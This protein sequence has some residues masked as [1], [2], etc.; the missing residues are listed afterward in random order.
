MPSDPH[1]KGSPWQLREIFTSPLKIPSENTNFWHAPTRLM[2]H[3]KSSTHGNNPPLI[4]RC[5]MPYPMKKLIE[6]NP[7]VCPRM[8]SATGILAWIIVLPRFI[9]PKLIYPTATVLVLFLVKY[10]HTGTAQDWNSFTAT[11]CQYHVMFPY[12]CTRKKLMFCVTSMQWNT[13]N[14]S[15]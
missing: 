13:L 7:R 9:H 5:E 8:L 15:S 4:L 12:P 2:G 10:V 3:R 6:A 11:R 14:R 1:W